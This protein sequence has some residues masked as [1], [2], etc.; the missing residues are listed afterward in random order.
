MKDFTVFTDVTYGAI[1]SNWSEI[2]NWLKLKVGDPDHEW[3]LNV[4]TATGEMTFAFVD[5]K[6][7][8]LFLLKWSQMFEILRNR[9]RTYDNS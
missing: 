1:P 9:E 8:T 6:M 4:D 2:Y 7:Q 3:G 5:S